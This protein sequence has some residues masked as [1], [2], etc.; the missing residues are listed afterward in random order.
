MTSSRRST[1][2]VLDDIASGPAPEPRGAFVRDLEARLGSLIQSSVE[3]DLMPEI[4]LSAPSTTDVYRGRLVGAASLAMCA[5]ALAVGISTATM[6]SAP[7]RAVST[8][9][10]P[11][12]DT[13]RRVDETTPAEEVDVTAGLEEVSEAA[14]SVTSSSA[15]FSTRRGFRSTTSSPSRSGDVSTDASA[16]SAPPATDTPVPVGPTADRADTASRQPATIELEAS[17]TA[18]RVFLSWSRYD[19]DDFAAYL[20]LRANDPDNP[21]HPD[22]SGRTLMLLRIENADMT[23]HQDTPKVGTSPRYRVVVVRKDGT[24]VA[25]SPVVTPAMPL[26]A[27]SKVVGGI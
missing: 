1:R 10:G 26:T 9:S 19:G 17:G 12:G 14:S 25:Q 16:S 15:P 8:A 11:M 18:A 4:E 13:T 21:S 7:S 5:L 27:S 3:G 6:G 2:A 23:S 22:A 24:V 20:V